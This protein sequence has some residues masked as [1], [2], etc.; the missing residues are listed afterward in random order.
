MD[1]D[2]IFEFLGNHWIMVGATVVVA[3][4]LAQDLIETLL[5][6]HKLVT[7]AGAVALMN[8]E[9]T[10][11]IDVREPHEFSAG[12][13]EN[14]RH[15]PLGKIDDRAYELQESK[16]SPVIVACQSGTRSPQACR[17]LAALGFTD[18]YELQGGMV[19]WEEAKLPI[20]RKR[21]KS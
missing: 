11:V 12:H 2:R 13:I 15:I 10:I 17:K 19:A 6:K 3:V 7:P 4:L 8:G 14:A 5:R 9:E 16:T 21:S 20:S 18:V 1:L